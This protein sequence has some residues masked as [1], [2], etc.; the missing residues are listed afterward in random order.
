MTPIHQHCSHVAVPNVLH[1][2]FSAQTVFFDGLRIPWALG[3]AL[4][5]LR[6]SQVLFPFP[7]SST[8]NM[9]STSTGYGEGARSL[10]FVESD[11]HLFAE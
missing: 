5:A 3:Y 11:P 2:P 1:V 7:F 10:L 6:L 9:Y 8:P 4:Y